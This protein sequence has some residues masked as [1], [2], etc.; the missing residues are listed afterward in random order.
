MKS[1]TAKVSLFLELIKCQ[2]NSISY[3]TLIISNIARLRLYANFIKI[4]FVAWLII[5]FPCQLLS[6]SYS[7][8]VK[9]LLDESTITNVELF[10]KKINQSVRT[11][12]EGIATLYLQNPSLRILVSDNIV[13]WNGIKPINLN[14]F[15][16]TGQLLKTIKI[17]YNQSEVELP[18]L[19]RGLYHLQLIG[20]SIQKALSFYYPNDK[21]RYELKYEI[22]NDSIYAQKD[23]YSNEVYNINDLFG[24]IYLLK[25]KYSYLKDLK[26]NI[27]FQKL[28]GL[29]FNS[30]F[31]E[32]ESVKLMYN[33]HDKDLWFF[34]ANE[35]ISHFNF[36]SQVLNYNKEAS[37]F[38]NTEYTLNDQRTYIPAYLNYYKSLNKY[39]LDFS[40][41][42]ELTCENISNLYEA[43]LDHSY[44]ERENLFYYNNMNLDLNCSNINTISSIE[45]NE[46][47]NYQPLSIQESYGY[48]RKI[49]LD[50]I[51]NK[52]IGWQDIVLTNGV[53]FDIGVVSGMITTEFQTQLSHVNILSHNRKTPNMALRNGWTQDKINNLV[54]KLIYLKVDLDSFEIREANIL[55][56]ETYWNTRRPKSWTMLELD[57]TTTGLID[58][59]NYGHFD[60]KTI[61]G[62]AANFAE[63]KKISAKQIDIPLPEFHFAIPMYYYQKHIQSNGIDLEINNLLNDSIFIK[64]ANKRKTQLQKI[65]DA[66]ITAPIDNSFLM[67][68][69]EK[70]KTGNIHYNYN[71]RSST[72]A[73]DIEG[74]NG[75]GLYDSYIGNINKPDKL[76][77]LAI[78][79]TWAS[80]WNDRAFDERNFFK[81]DAHSIAMAILVHRSFSNELANGVVI[82]KNI[83]SPINDAII[84]NVQVG[85]ISVVRPEDHYLPDQII[86]YTF[87]INDNAF[88]YT[89]HTNVPNFK[90]KSILSDEEL[91]ELQQYCLTIRDHFCNIDP[92]CKPLDI[93]FK[94]DLIDGKRKIYIK[95][96]RYY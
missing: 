87:K 84:I 35:Y 15:S 42:C 52:F 50:S 86:Y 89:S 90:A 32:I 91:K 77:D 58:L 8:V 67:K 25:Y 39:V 26:Y 55:E 53:P 23:G 60:G 36:A 1:L 27:A 80:L 54:D 96:A 33:I 18:D 65:R 10:N 44:I 94:V 13:R 76:I 72:N 69:I 51:E 63:L 59:N 5:L 68:V 45:I 56:A 62:K 48:L 49:P 66:I 95:Q 81:I 57:T 9:D 2:T 3:F 30:T 83:Y 75:A 82:T 85:E 4:S 88:E 31:S 47:Q 46:G 37:L 7:F 14:I 11:N 73:E 29:P 74:F 34:N 64:D 38:V 28:K 17:Q 71:F 20:D 41:F 19:S 43:I 78:K 6:Q 92:P 12:S 40:A 61:G 21:Y 93:E 70:I 79:K 24:T 22:K 16:N